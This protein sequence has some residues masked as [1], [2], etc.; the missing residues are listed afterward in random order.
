ML[1]YNLYN[2]CITYRYILFK[3]NINDIF[4]KFTKNKCKNIVLIYIQNISIN[5]NK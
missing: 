4:Y 1:I 5:F 2:I 3:L